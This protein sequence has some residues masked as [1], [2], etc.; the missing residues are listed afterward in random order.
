MGQPLSHSLHRSII[1]SVSCTPVI[2]LRVENLISDSEEYIWKRQ[3]D[4]VDGSV[5]IESSE[6]TQSAILLDLQPRSATEVPR[7]HHTNSFELNQRRVEERRRSL[8]LNGRNDLHF[9]QPKV[10]ISVLMIQ[11][12]YGIFYINY[13][14]MI[15]PT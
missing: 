15:S 1:F 4:M 7:V 3:R 14:E 13:F 12:C 9:P 11:D 8:E 6:N 2:C 10:S 5:E